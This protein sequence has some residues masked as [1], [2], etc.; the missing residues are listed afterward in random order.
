MQKIALFLSMSLLA[1]ITLKVAYYINAKI[2]L[3]LMGRYLS[4]KF[5]KFTIIEIL[6]CSVSSFSFSYSII[7]KAEKT[8]FPFL[9]IASGILYLIYMSKRAWLLSS[10]N[11]NNIKSN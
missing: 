10:D 1:F 9:F 5:V 3:T 8:I 7:Y 2:F 6:I 11:S 4:N